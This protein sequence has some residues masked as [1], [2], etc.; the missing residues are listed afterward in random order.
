LLLK[1]R[2]EV[3]ERKLSYIA[4]LIAFIAF[5]PSIDVGQAHQ[6]SRFAK[7]LGYR[8]YCILALARDTSSF[9]PFK[10]DVGS[11][12]RD[13]LSDAQSS[14]LSDCWD[15][16]VKGFLW[17]GTDFDL[18]LYEIRPA[19]FRCSLLEQHLQKPWA[20]KVFRWKTSLLSRIC[21]FMGTETYP[22]KKN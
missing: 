9:D 8:Q 13:K 6:L 7:E 5:D 22:Q 15:L 17:T 10:Q 11:I 4:K 21:S 2:Q 19:T 16:K 12:G 3:E 14:F 1:A 18:H 20:S